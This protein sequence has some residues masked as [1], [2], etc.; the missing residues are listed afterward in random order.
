[1]PH[2]SIPHEYAGWWR[3]TETSVWAAK[4]L[5]ILGPALISFGTGRGD[6]LR[7]IAILADVNARF[8]RNGVSFTWAGASEFDP[9]AGTGRARLGKDG[10]LKGTLVITGGDK[11]TF[12]A[13]RTEEPSEPIPYPPSYQ[14]KWHRW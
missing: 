14:E 9:I 12:L 3:I 11:S 13:E 4:H 1:M 10:R 6:R 7:V 5:D 8:V 2:D